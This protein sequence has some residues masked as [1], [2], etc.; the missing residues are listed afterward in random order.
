MGYLSSTQL[1]VQDGKSNKHT[2]HHPTTLEYL[3]QKSTF[4]LPLNSRN[5]CL[6]RQDLAT[7]VQQAAREPCGDRVEVCQHLIMIQLV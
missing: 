5:R 4:Y 2:T 3:F 7:L 6:N 1:L